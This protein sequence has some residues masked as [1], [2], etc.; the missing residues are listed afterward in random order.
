MCQV[1]NRLGKWDP[2]QN[3]VGR[4]LRKPPD[5]KASGVAAAYANLQF[6]TKTVS[7]DA[8]APDNPFGLRKGEVVVDLPDQFDAS[9]YF[10]GR[11]RTPWHSRD[12]CPKNGR[13][14]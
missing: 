1:Y 14:S 4:D 6:M 10:I 8:E 5:P 12:A 11:I 2:S 9:L 7:P 3:G 13:E